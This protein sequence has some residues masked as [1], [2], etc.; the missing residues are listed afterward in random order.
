MTIQD[1]TAFDASYFREIFITACS[2]DKWKEGFKKEIGLVSIKV[3]PNL[4]GCIN[5]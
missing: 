2:L 4:I 5:I 3:K 1:R